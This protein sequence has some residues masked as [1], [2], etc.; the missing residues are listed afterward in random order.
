MNMSG[1]SPSAQGVC[2]GV[3]LEKK[4]QRRAS[5][6]SLRCCPLARSLVVRRAIR[7][8]PTQRLL[9]SGRAKLRPSHPTSY[10]LVNTPTQRIRHKGLDFANGYPQCTCTAH[11]TVQICRTHTDAVRVLANASCTNTTTSWPVPC[12]PIMP[13]GD[14][15]VMLHADVGPSL[16]DWWPWK[17]KARSARLFQM[18]NT[19]SLPRDGLCVSARE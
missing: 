1:F 19:G 8:N 11:D 3:V 4:L 14:A 6:V 5:P 15:I 2:S 17:R 13:A 18:T 16:C 9:W 12:P 10:F 7:S